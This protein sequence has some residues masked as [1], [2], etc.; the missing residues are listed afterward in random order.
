MA[1]LISCNGGPTKSLENKTNWVTQTNAKLSN[2]GNKIRLSIDPNDS[3]CLVHSGPNIDSD[4]V[5]FIL[6]DDKNGENKLFEIAIKKG[7]QKMKF[8]GMNNREWVA[9]L[10]GHKFILVTKP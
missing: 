7:F 3:S 6:E 10:K 1:L 8:I 5:K 9:T 2:S 4:M